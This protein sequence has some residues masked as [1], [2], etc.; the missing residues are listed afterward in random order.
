MCVP[1]PLFFCNFTIISPQTHVIFSISSLNLDETPIT[2]YTYYISSEG[3]AVDNIFIAIIL[4]LVVAGILFPLFT[5]D[6]KASRDTFQG[7]KPQSD[8]VRLLKMMK[9]KLK[10]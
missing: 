9:D 10:K 7:Q 4:A 6:L 5:H 3:T 8:F 1:N 2:A